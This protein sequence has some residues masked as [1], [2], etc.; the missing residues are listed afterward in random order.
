M[1]INEITQRTVAS[2]MSFIRGI[3]NLLGTGQLP[4][5][6]F[7]TKPLIG[8][9]AAIFSGILGQT[10]WHYDQP[11]VIEINSQILGD[12]NT[13]RRVLAHELCH[14]AEFL[15][16]WEP[17]IRGKRNKLASFIQNKL[18]YAAGKDYVV[19]IKQA[20]EMSD[21]FS[22]LLKEISRKLSDPSNSHGRRWKAY[23][24]KVNAKYGKDFVT[25]LSDESYILKK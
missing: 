5:P 13:T 9:A 8:G 25:P 2:E 12:K 14:E 7:E 10:T 3:R 19:L 1:Q 21:K 18:A 22:V 15:L 24:N 17:L 20:N 16:Y 6:I 4:L 11:V 23:A